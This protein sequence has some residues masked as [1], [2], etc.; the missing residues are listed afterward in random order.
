MKN[1][2][3]TLTDMRLRIHQHRIQRQLSPAAIMMLRQL[4][5]S[6]QGKLLAR[7]LTPDWENRLLQELLAAF[8]QHGIDF[9]ELSVE[10]AVTLLFMLVSEDAR[11]DSKAVLQ[12]MNEARLQRSQM[13]EVLTAKEPVTLR[14]ALDYFSNLVATVGGRPGSRGSTGGFLAV[15]N[16]AHIDLR[17]ILLLTEYAASTNVVQFVQV[18]LRMLTFAQGNQE[19]E[20]VAWCAA[21]NALNCPGAL[22]G[23]NCELAARCMRQPL[24]QL[25]QPGL[26]APV[27]GAKW[28]YYR[29]LKLRPK[30]S[31]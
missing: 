13:R 8:R 23:L 12:K 19:Y 25:V 17:S 31:R 6:L 5:W 27:P 21:I 16:P 24:P 30:E 22:I 3:S 20:D 4:A 18:W 1:E 10:D 11:E 15:A 26:Y 2:D 29:D 9:S 7:R 14:D 28:R